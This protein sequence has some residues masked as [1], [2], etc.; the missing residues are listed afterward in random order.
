VSDTLGVVGGMI[1]EVL[2]E[3]GA[4][5]EPI[6]RQTSFASDL[7]LESIEF[8]ALAEKLQGH[9]GD[10][11]DFVTWLSGKELDELV[12][13]KV[14]DLVEHIDHCLSETSTA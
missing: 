9:Y 12:G 7:E 1:L 4:P 14:G 11:V 13:L 3:E 10:R 8:V 5:D 6:T 2:G